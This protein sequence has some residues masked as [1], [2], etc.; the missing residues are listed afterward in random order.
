[1]DDTSP[2]SGDFVRRRLPW[3]IAGAALILYGLTLN[4]WIGPGSLEATTQMAGWEGAIPFNRPLLWLVSLPL[5]LLP[6]TLL[7]VAANW[8]AALFAAAALGTLA[9]CV[10]LLPHNHTRE[11]RMRGHA[12]EPLLHIRLAWVPPLFAALLLGLQLTFWEE[13]TAQTGE[14]LDLLIFATCIRCLLEYRLGLRESWLRRFALLIGVGIAGNWAMIGYA[15]LF[16]LAL[17]WIRGLAILDARFLLG[18]MA[19]FFTGLL[20]YL[21][22]PL[23]SQIQFGG[24]QGFWPVLHANLSSQK[25]GLLGLPRSKFLLLAL[26]SLLPLVLVGIRWT[27]TIGSRFENLVKSAT[28]ILLQAAFLGVAVYMAFDPAFSPR[29]LVRL[30]PQQGRLALLTFGFSGTLA[31]GYF[32]GYF[33]LVGGQKPS[34]ARERSTPVPRALGSLAAGLV[35]LFSLAVPVFLVL[36]NWPAIRAQNGPGLEHFAGNLTALLPARPTIL[37]TDDPALQQLAQAYFRSRK[38]G[39]GHLLF[40][41]ALAANAAYRQRLAREYGAHW[42]E[43]ARFAD[44]H[45]GVAVPFLQLLNRAVTN[46]AA[47]YLNPA[48]NFIT[49]QLYP[50]PVGGLY[51]LTAYVPGQVAPPAL[52]VA[53]ATAIGRYWDRLQPELDAV[54]AASGLD[55]PNAKQVAALWSR[56]ANTE[57][58]LLQ[59][60]GHLDAAAKLFARARGLN[61]KNVCSLV[62]SSVNTA[63]RAHLP[64]T[65]D[66]RKPLADQPLGNSLYQHGPLDEPQTLFAIARSIGLSANPLPRAAAIRFLRASELDPTFTMAA[67]GYISACVNANEAGMA[68]AAAQALR[69]R[70]VLKPEDLSELI[71]LE[72]AAL[73]LRDDVSGVEKLLVKARGELPKDTVAYDLLSQLYIQQGRND[74]ALQLV[75]QWQLMQPEDVNVSLRKGVIL[76]SQQHFDQAI[77]QLDRVLIQRPNHEVARANRAISLL[78]LNR[79]DDARRDYEELVHQSPDQYRYHFGLGKIADQKNEPSEAINHFRRY[80]ELAPTNTTEFND[81]VARL[82]QL[83]GGK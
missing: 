75:V 76:M 51:R 37:L 53:E 41:S 19:W 40:N 11:A 42:P 72:V 4:P 14:M 12:D 17:G 52:S 45:E 23:V 8:V 3:L 18:L 73:M 21:L 47:Y 26:V 38:G 63:L 22:V 58:V 20:A 67:L 65:D 69:T 36:R 80:L 56:A 44:A 54:T 77:P 28:V 29:Q 60:S 71:R 2:F 16:L 49:E 10:A 81:I 6:A 39:D 32:A 55:A 68:L 35:L 83:Q 27:G 82:K 46:Q 13:A 1:M 50:R 48:V 74:E 7:P 78:Q 66:L 24:D 5:K 61:D 30:D 9:R 79:L 15:P 43:L 64:I 59:Q 31:A 62:N 34:N 57:G 33:L 25:F 70:Q